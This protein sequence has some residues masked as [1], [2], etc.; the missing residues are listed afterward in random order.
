V[1]FVLLLA[2]LDELVK[3]YVLDLLVGTADIHGN[4]VVSGFI[5]TKHEDVRVL[6]ILEGLDLRLHVLVGVIRLDTN[7]GLQKKLLNF[8][9]VLVMLLA[10]WNQRYLIR[11]QPER[12]ITLEVLLVFR[13]KSIPWYD[14]LSFISVYINPAI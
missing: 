11:I 7:T 14:L 8:V 1:L 13:K 10:D 4:R 9:C 6:E 5:V 2:E 3:R 12:E